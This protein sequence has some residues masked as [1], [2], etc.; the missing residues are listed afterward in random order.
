[1]GDWTAEQLDRVGAGDK[2]EIASYQPDGSL[3]PW[4]T[5]WVVR[6]GD[7]LYVRTH[8]GR[9]GVWIRHA[10]SVMRAAPTPAEPRATSSS[11]KCPHG[12]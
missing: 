6:V 11:R 12:P 4:V 9:Q 10:G 1:M 2:G 8:T 3:R 7:D 5:G